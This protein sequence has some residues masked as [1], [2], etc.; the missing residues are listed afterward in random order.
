MKKRTLTFSTLDELVQFSKR[1]PGGYLLN[2]INLTIIITVS[3]EQLQQA[4]NCQPSG[5]IS[6]VDE[7]ISTAA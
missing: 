6:Q 7:S 2:T 1:L 5:I 4:L 3:E